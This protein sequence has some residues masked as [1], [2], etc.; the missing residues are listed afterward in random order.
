[1]QIQRDRPRMA[2]LPSRCTRLQFRKMACKKIL[3][4]GFSAHDCRKS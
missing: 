2:R 4:K 1:V 3:L